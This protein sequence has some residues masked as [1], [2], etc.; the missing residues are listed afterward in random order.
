M[1]TNISDEEQE[2]MSIY[3]SFKLS[4]NYTLFARYDD[5]TETSKLG[6]I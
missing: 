1:P 4:D 5:A 3:G 2:L 6:H